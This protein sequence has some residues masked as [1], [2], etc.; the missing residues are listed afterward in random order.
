M[1]R[2]RHRPYLLALIFWM[3]TPLP[4]GCSWR[5][6]ISVRVP[7]PASNAGWKSLSNQMPSLATRTLHPRQQINPDTLCHFCAHHLPQDGG[8]QTGL[9]V[10]QLY[11]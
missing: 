2:G 7:S 3:I 5:N 1:S 9:P 6:W 4:M 10:R 8:G 11:G